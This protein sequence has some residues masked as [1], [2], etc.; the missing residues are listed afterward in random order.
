MQDKIFDLLLEQEEVTWKTLILDL[1]KSEE[2]NP[3][4]INITL[5]TQKYIQVI[6]EMQ[7]HDLRISGKILLAAAIL[8]KIKS[9][10]LIDHDI[11]RLDQLIH[12]EEEELGEE[13]LFEELSSGERKLRE[14]YKLIPKNP[15]PRTR[16]VS[17]NDLIS[18]LQ[19]AMASKRRILAKQ[20]PQK[21]VAPKKGIDILEVIRELYHK[22]VYYNKKDEKKLTF[23][24]L[25]PPKASKRQKVHTFVPLLH[26]ENQQKVETTQKEAFDEIYVK[27]LKGK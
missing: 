12:Q 4:D 9:S 2:M 11:T 27:L 10:H 20:R 8:L 3:W 18:A 15:Q 17:V 13:D 23:S 22:I 7:E 19:K 6:K 21:F 5:L 25:L 1:V 24:R 16:K 14:K 26:L